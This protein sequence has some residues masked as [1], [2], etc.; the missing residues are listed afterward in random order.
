M[1]F[2]SLFKNRAFQTTLLVGLFLTSVLIIVAMMLGNESGNFVI[3]VESGDIEK[4]IGITENLEENFYPKKITVEGLKGISDDTPAYFLGDGGYDEQLSTLKQLTANPGRKIIGD[5]LYVYTFY[6]V[7]TG[8][9]ALNIEF[10]MN[11]SNITRGMDEAVRVMTY[12]E[13]DEVINI[14]QKRDTQDVNYERYYI[15][16][17][18]E[19]VSDTLAYTER[20][21]VRSGTVEDKGYVKYSVLFWLEG[22]DPECIENIKEGTIRFGLNV[23]VVV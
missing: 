12:N 23:K 2:V 5:S 7:S 4:S 11:I 6:V 14:Y 3:Q 21:A 13:T 22:Q 18:T 19:F 15:S 1:S 16:G 10:S 20:A 8:S 9:G 17:T